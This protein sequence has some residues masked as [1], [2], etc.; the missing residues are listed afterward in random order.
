ML[1]RQCVWALPALGIATSA[2]G[3]ANGQV[4][5]A[6]GLIWIDWIVIAL[7]AAGTIAL[8]WYFSR[9]QNTTQEY[10]IGKGSMS[11]ILVGISLFATLLSTIS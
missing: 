4:D 8:G 10:F 6:T 9:R 11:P 3:A 5:E 7:Y 2:A 1:V